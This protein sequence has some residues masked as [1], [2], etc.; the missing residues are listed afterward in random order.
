MP[1][2]GEE[3]DQTTDNNDRP[4]LLVDYMGGIDHRVE[5]EVDAEEQ[6]GHDGEEHSESFLVVHGQNWK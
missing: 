5:G 1:P 2:H 3:E 4:H 6:D